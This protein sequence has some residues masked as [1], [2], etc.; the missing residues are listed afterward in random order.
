MFSSCEVSY[1][2]HLIMYYPTLFIWEVH[3]TEYPYLDITHKVEDTLHQF[4]ELNM[5]QQ[6]RTNVSLR[7]LETQVG[8]ITMHL[9]QSQVSQPEELPTTPINIEHQPP[10]PEVV[11]SKGES[12][13]IKL[14]DATKLV[15]PCFLYS[16][17]KHK[18]IAND[19]IIGIHP[20]LQELVTRS[21]PIAQARIS[22]SQQ[23]QNAISRPGEP[24]LAQTRIL[25]YSP[26][27]HPPRPNPEEK[28][29][30]SKFLDKTQSRSAHR[31]RQHLIDALS[32]RAMASEGEAMR[33]T[34]H[35]LSVAKSNAHRKLMRPR[36]VPNQLEPTLSAQVVHKEYKPLS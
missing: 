6:R 28:T 2:D 23:P 13:E 33:N 19:H 16:Y 7:D 36:V 4:M 9:S 20:L 21:D 22:Q 1:I 11:D 31:K 24:T 10:I 32:A 5:E 27:F 30:N 3:Y 18:V 15:G 25:Q 8:V 34:H 12:V 35:S 29:K 26:G 17:L 14:V